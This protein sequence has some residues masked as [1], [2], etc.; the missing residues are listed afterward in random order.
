M[1]LVIYIAIMTVV[2]VSTTDLAAH[3]VFAQTKVNQSSEVTDNI[4]FI[5]AKLNQDLQDSTAISGT[6]PSNILNFN[7]AT[8][9]E[10]Y[11][12]AGG[13]LFLSHDGG[14]PVAISSDKVV[15]GANGGS[16]GNI[17]NEIVNGSETTIT[18]NLQVSLKNNSSIVTDYHT[19]ILSRGK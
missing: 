5:S 17:F 18:I 13:V 11:S 3:L 12:L 1:E 15:V 6:Y 8:H 7:V 19:T 9:T 4:N 16:T 2:L 14:E 10:Q